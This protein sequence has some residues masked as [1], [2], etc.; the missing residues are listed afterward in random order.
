[1]KNSSGGSTTAARP[2]EI[3]RALGG[4][5]GLIKIAEK[6][7]REFLSEIASRVVVDAVQR[8]LHAGRWKTQR[9]AAKHLGISEAALSQ[10]P[11]RMPRMAWEKV[12]DILDRLGIEWVEVAPERR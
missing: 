2:R 11:K 5:K 1:M 3:V 7:R 12:A 10:L 4:E 8:E 6:A 9:Q